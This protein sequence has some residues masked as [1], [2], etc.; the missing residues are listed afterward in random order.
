MLTN[1]AVCECNIY[2]T[3]E[4]FL[5]NIALAHLN[6][7]DTLNTFNESRKNI[8]TERKKALHLSNDEELNGKTEPG[9]R[10]IKL[11]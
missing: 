3:T 6:V 10:L 7:V 1:F 8:R 9:S 4:S 11:R 5:D 2:I